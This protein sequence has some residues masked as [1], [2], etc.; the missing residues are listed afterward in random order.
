MVGDRGIF[1]TPAEARHFPCSV[2]CACWVCT[3][4]RVLLNGYR[5]LFP[6]L[7]RPGHEADP[8]LPFVARSRTALPLLPLP[9]DGT[10][11][12]FRN[13]Y[14]MSRIKCTIHLPCPEL[15]ASCVCLVNW[16]SK[17]SCTV[18]CSWPSVSAAIREGR[19]ASSVLR[20]CSRT[21]K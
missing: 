10:R 19:S 9:E 14:S 16:N 18:C 20:K 17:F 1:R 12:G 7:E 21:E 2:T 15:F 6:G 4:P 8:P 3:S 11:T 5:Q 13:V